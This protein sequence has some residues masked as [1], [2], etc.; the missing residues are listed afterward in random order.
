MSSNVVYFWQHRCSGEIPSINIHRIALNHRTT[1]RCRGQFAPRVSSATLESHRARYH[2]K[3]WKSTGP[4]FETG[5]AEVA[6]TDMNGQ[7]SLES[8]I[9]GASY[10]FAGTS[11]YDTQDTA[12]EKEQGLAIAKAA[13]QTAQ[14]TRSLH[15]EQSAGSTDTI[16]ALP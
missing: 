14:N 3:C 10:I 6:Q 11:F 13:M 1:G 4:S 5:G 2:Q 7:S 12:L 16:R 8:A 15:L 9:D